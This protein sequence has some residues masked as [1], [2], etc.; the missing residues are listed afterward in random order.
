M[1]FATAK[2]GESLY[3]CTSIG[4]KTYYFKCRVIEKDDD[5]FILREVE[6]M[7]TKFK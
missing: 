6:N 3:V 4:N 2:E 1:T 5:G 7:T